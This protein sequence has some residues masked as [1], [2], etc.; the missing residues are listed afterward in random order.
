MN[1]AT[2]LSYSF[3]ERNKGIE[4]TGYKQ[5]QDK[6]NTATRAVLFKYLDI[7]LFFHR[8]YVEGTRTD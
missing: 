1:E 7:N 4:K 8:K 5:L 3:A 2:L 6:K